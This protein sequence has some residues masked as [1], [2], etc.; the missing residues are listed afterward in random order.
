MPTIRRIAVLAALTAMANTGAEAAV[1]PARRDLA[2]VKAVLAQ[3][4]KPPSKLRP[5][6]IMLV[7]NRKDHGAHEHDYPRWMERWKVLLGGKRTSG[8]SPTMYGIT[9]HLPPGPKPGARNVRV[10]T[11][12]DWPTAQQLE[13]ADVVVAFMGTGGIWNEAKLRDL[14]ALLDRGK[15]FVALHAAVI[16]EK[17]HARRLAELLGLAWE[18]GTTLFRH[19]A[20]DLKITAKDDPITRGLPERIHFEDESYWPLVGDAS[21]VKVLATADEAERGRLAP[22][23]MFWTHT[24]GKGRVF[25]SILG[26]YSWTF[27]DPYFRILALRG[28]AWAAGESPYRFD[29]V[30]LAGARV[31]EKKPE[32][33]KVKVAAP[34]APDAADPDLLL[35]LDASDAGTL[36]AGADGKVSAWA[37]KARRAPA[38]L[39]AAGAKQ[40]LLVRKA[41]GGKPAVRFDGIDDVLREGAFRQ[42]AR[43]WT[44]ALVVTPRSNAGSFRALLAAGKPGQD[45]FQTGLN[46][47]LGP[48]QTP[49]FNSLNVE[50]I[51]GGGAT[52]LRTDAAPFGSGQVLLISTGGGSSRLWVN[53]HEEEGRGASDAVTAMEELRLGGRFYMGAERGY[54]HGDISEV[55]VYRTQLAEPQRDGLIA[56]L[57]QK[58]GPDIQ[59][60]TSVALDPWDYLPAY[61]W[62]STRRPL[63]PIDEWV[64]GAKSDARARKA[65]EARLVEVAGDPANP[66][67]ARDYA[68]RR[69]AIIGSAA[70]VPALARML[71]E[72]A[73]AP[74]AC[75][76]LERI[77]G[78][79][80]EKALIEALGTV[81]GKQRTEVV[82][83]LGSRRSRP[84]VR[85]LAGLA[86]A[87]DAAT[88]AAVITALG[89]IGGPEAVSVLN[90]ILARA[91]GAERTAAA[92]ALLRCAEQYEAAGRKPEAAAVYR[93]L[94][95]KDV[96]ESAQRAAVRGLI[97]LKGAESGPTLVELLN[98]TPEARALALLLM[99]EMEAPA[100]V[101]PLDDLHP[102]ARA[103]MLTVLADRGEKDQL[104]AV[105]ASFTSQHPAVRIAALRALGRLGD[106][107]HVPAL[108]DAV[109][110]EDPDMAAAARSAL[111]ALSGPG[112]DA[113]LLAA[114]DQGPVSSRA[115]AI[116]ALGRRAHAPAAGALLRAAQGPEP[117]LRVAALKALGEVAG[118]GDVA[119]LAA[120]LTAAKDPTEA[121]EAEKA[122]GVLHARLEEKDRWVEALLARLP[123]AAP[124]A[125]T[126]LLRLV[127]LHGGPKAL[128]AVKRAVNDPDEDVSDEALGLLV[129]WETVDAAEPLLAIAKAAA[130][131]VRKTLALR[132]YLRMA[133]RPAVPAARRLEMVRTGL[134]LAERDDDRRVALAA[135]AGIP[136]LEALRIALP[137][138]EQEALAEE[139][140][141]AVVAI[142]QK[143]L[144][145]HQS[146]V[147]EAADRVLQRVKSEEVRR[148]AT[149]LRARAG[150]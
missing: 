55:L 102:E 20:L 17:P 27:D 62:G 133:G 104:P 47:D 51:K 10:E 131:P 85:A 35:W 9:A 29:P 93:R 24:V 141:A 26:H 1:P 134:D 88:R 69:L 32:V 40:P 150:N 50:G 129:D 75:F 79:E 60:P 48:G 146:E 111:A 142:G 63:A 126:A 46:L 3:A 71:S 78:S 135:L 106:A 122:L 113:A 119:D 90:E 2:E 82:A 108:L 54:F 31:T 33:A 139:A 77:P 105:L 76:A 130:N 147:R 34:V 132:G 11:A 45:D 13:R 68:C 92:G 15:G 127:S 23:P 70:S 84:A 116:E 96:P 72:P 87:P 99:R 25:N 89:N 44:I 7:A 143:L 21:R 38:R 49:A 101:I 4:P 94:R 125:K 114:V 52:N 81:P 22:Q 117:T 140:G 6:N 124:D 121:Q 56:H 73:L 43:E 123:G 149:D 74:I 136:S 66:A 64:A 112:V 8:G 80:A 58:Y 120:I 39:T 36:S 91:Q 41:L 65:L 115:A 12:A 109:D 138:L 37:S 137:L 97:L 57:M 19:G 103:L 59:P 67:G 14:K 107:S 148:Q 86:T 61:D 5:L 83:A 18:G 30:V 28:I 145:E 100:P 98:G 118:I 110:A 53:G 128:E 95:E 144:P 16:A 42:S